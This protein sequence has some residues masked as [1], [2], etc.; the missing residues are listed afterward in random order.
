MDGGA[1]IFDGQYGSQKNLR[2][3]SSGDRLVLRGED[4]VLGENQ[5]KILLF[6]RMFDIIM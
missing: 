4:N 1:W 6:F 2:A 3:C 5:L